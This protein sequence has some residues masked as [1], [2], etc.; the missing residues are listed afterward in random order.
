M[1]GQY[2]GLQKLYETYKDK[3]FEIIACPCNQ[4]AGQEPGSSSE[5]D[6]RIR[7]KYNVT[8]TILE[9]LKVNGSEES[10]FYTYLK[11]KL[12]GMLGSKRIMWNFTKFLVDREGYP[13]ARF[14]SKTLPKDLGST[15][16]ELLSKPIE[17]EAADGTASPKL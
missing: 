17:R 12:P 3:G 10:L 5:I 8:F 14:G 11:S 13:C 7:S 1:T 6:D 4:F 16:E 15:I 2:R 9:K